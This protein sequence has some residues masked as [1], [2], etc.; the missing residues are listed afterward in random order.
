MT[1]LLILA[2]LAQDEPELVYGYVALGSPTARFLPLGE[3]SYRPSVRGRP[4]SLTVEFTSDKRVGFSRIDFAT[5]IKDDVPSALWYR[6]KLVHDETASEPT[7]MAPRT[8]DKTLHVIRY[9]PATHRFSGVKFSPYVYW[10]PDLKTKFE[11]ALVTCEPYRD[12]SAPALPARNRRIDFCEA[13]PTP[14]PPL[15][16]PFRGTFETIY[17]YVAMGT[18]ASHFLPFTDESEPP[19]SYGDVSSVTVEF[20]AGDQTKTVLFAER[21]GFL[22]LYRSELP[23]AFEYRIKLVADPDRGDPEMIDPA[24]FEDPRMVVRYNPTKWIFSKVK[25]GNLRGR[26]LD[27][28]LVAC[29]PFPDMTARTGRRFDFCEATPTERPAPPSRGTPEMIVGY[30]SLADRTIP[31]LPSGDGKRHDIGRPSRVYAEFAS[32][33][34]GETRRLEWRNYLEYNRQWMAACYNRER[35]IGLYYTFKLISDTSRGEPRIVEPGLESEPRMIA[36]FNPD[37]WT[38]VGLK[39]GPYTYRKPENGWKVIERPLAPCDPY[40]EWETPRLRIPVRRQDFN[41]SGAPVERDFRPSDKP[42][43]DT[44]EP[45]PQP[46]PMAV[47]APPP[48]RPEGP[49]REFIG[50]FVSVKGGIPT[51]ETPGARRPIAATRPSRLVFEFASKTPG[52]PAKQIVYEAEFQWFSLYDGDKIP[53]LWYVVEVEGRAGIGDPKKA[54]VRDARDASYVIHYDSAAWTFSGVKVGP[55][56]IDEKERTLVACAEYKD[57][58]WQRTG[59]TVRRFDFGEPIQIAPIKPPVKPLPPP[60]KPLPVPVPPPKK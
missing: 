41:E 44:G 38:F 60:I 47:A 35:P 59:Q 32:K 2:L 22:R 57:F 51:K 42:D 36:R 46:A 45:E 54:P 37:Q 43:G 1:T 40:P 21:M 52:T 19:G 12:L 18:P 29:D 9:N 15:P 26:G 23:T 33:T 11:R 24:G 7:A 16:K 27:R 10:T 53:A 20:T 49:K 48:P 34:S 3:N 4:E 5:I 55:M 6:I 14:P 39:M 58:T 30:I 17:G 50:G 28:A 8:E 56:M 25:M 31:S 13:E